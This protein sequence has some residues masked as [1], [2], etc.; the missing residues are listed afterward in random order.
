MWC[1]F[2]NFELGISLGIQHEV[3][4][5]WTIQ[6]ICNILVTWLKFCDM[7]QRLAPESACA[8]VKT[9]LKR[10]QVFSEINSYL[11]DFNSSFLQQN[12]YKLD[13]I[14]TLNFFV[15]IAVRVSQKLYLKLSHLN[16]TCGRSAI[17][18]SNHTGTKTFYYSDLFV[19]EY[20]FYLS[21]FRCFL[22]G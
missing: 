2:S 11:L 9:L 18:A 4:H 5:D 20:S 6:I 21:S 14:H 10:A 7:L 15:L 19:L 1:H 22:F 17:L 12:V 16:F 8:V 13:N 3:F